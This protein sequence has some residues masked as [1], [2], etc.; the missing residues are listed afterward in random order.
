MKPA[1]VILAAGM[2][3]RYGGLKQI[4]RIGKNG[5]VLLDY[6]VYDA[7]QSGFGKV[8]F[9]IRRDMEQDFKGIVLD[10][11]GTSLS[12]V[13]AFQEMDS[14][15]TPELA[16]YTAHIGRTKPWGTV[17][18]LLCTASLI[19]A[20]YVVINADDFYG[21]E[22]FKV[23]GAYLAGANTTEGAIIPYK[24]EKTL[25]P[26]GTVT[27]G[28]CAIENGYLVSVDELKEIEKQGGVIFNTGADGTRL[29]LAAHTPVSMN[30]WGFPPSTLP[31]FHRYFNEFCETSG[32]ELKSEC[33]I[34]LAVDWF[35][36]NNRLKIKVL[37]AE[38]EWFGVTYREDREAAR[39]RIVEL[40]NMG[41]YPARL[42]G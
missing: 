29:E 10:R 37:E 1:L 39:R 36:K 15:I 28:V 5:E 9:V 7:L 25:S 4:D 24:L 20:P 2:G 30:F 40:T 27:R 22:A 23:M 33:Y 11:M 31:H 19:D 18:A 13:L 32:R 14:L 12:Y 34:P 6:S 17:H 8:V 38:S 26:K 16:V 42:W 35:I 41:V 21:R 3:S